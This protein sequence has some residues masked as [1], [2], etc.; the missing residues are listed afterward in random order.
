M[1][2]DVDL[3]DY[4]EIGGIKVPQTVRYKDGTQDK[5]SYQFNVEY[6]EDIFT[7][8]PHIDAGPEAWKVKR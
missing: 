8:P 1:I 2:T 5:K 4:V 7:K 6:K 3:S